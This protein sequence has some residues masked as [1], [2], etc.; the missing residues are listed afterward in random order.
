MARQHD[1]YEDAE[2]EAY[3]PHEVTVQLHLVGASDVRR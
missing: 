2:E 1:S 3:P